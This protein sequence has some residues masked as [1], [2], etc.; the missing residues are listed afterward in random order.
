MTKIYLVALFLI[1]LFQNHFFKIKISGQIK[2][3]KIILLNLENFN[4]K[5]KNL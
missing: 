1:I 5:R 3:L 4:Y 2:D